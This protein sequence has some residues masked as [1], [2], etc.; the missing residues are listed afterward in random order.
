MRPDER[1]TPA[2]QYLRTTSGRTYQSCERVEGGLHEQMT[3]RWSVPE[4]NIVNPAPA[5]DPRPTPYRTSVPETRKQTLQ[6]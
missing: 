5:H 2:N 1:L 3:I 6:K 4:G